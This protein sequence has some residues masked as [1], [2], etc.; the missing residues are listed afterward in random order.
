M[1]NEKMKE[2]EKIVKEATYKAHDYACDATY[3]AYDYV[4]NKADE[5][6]SNQKSQDTQELVKSREL[7]R[8]YRKLAVKLQVL[9]EVYQKNMNDLITKLYN[10]ELNSTSNY[11]E[12]EE[13]EATDGGNNNEAEAAALLHEKFP[14]IFEE[15]KTTAFIDDGKEEVKAVNP[16]VSQ[17]LL[18]Y[19]EFSAPWRYVGINDKEDTNGC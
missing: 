11:C 12:E 16:S 14:H 10:L 7:L 8:Q 18:Q 19:G 17:S 1:E 9:R 3:K 6:I 5:Y 2:H 15:V 13:S 4:C